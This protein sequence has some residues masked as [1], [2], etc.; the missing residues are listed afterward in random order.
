VPRPYYVLGELTSGL[1]PVAR[2]AARLAGLIEKHLAPKRKVS[3]RQEYSL[4]E[5]PAGEP[6]PYYPPTDWHCLKQCQ[7]FLVQDVSRWLVRGDDKAR[8]MP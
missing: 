6:V 8:S 3:K 2:Y 4:A 1:E 7:D 5:F